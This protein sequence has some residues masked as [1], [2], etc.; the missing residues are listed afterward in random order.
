[1]ITREDQEMKKVSILLSI[2]RPDRE[3]L[4]EQLDSLNNQTYPNLELLVWNDCPDE[5]IDRELFAE[6]I[7]RFPVFYYG[8]KKNLGYI[9]AF[10]KLT[11]LAKGDLVSFCDQDDIW[12]TEKIEKCVSAMRESGAIAAVCDKSL[13]TANGEVYVKSYRATSTMHCDRWNTGDD[14]TPRAAFFC[15]GT[16]MTIVADRETVQG[17]LPFVPTVTHDMQLMLFLSAKGKIA[18]VDEPL[19]RYRR[20]GK[21]ET[22]LLYGVEKK[23]D[24]YDTRCKPGLDLMDRFAE[25]FP[26]YPELPEMIQ[27][28]NARMNGNAI[29]IWKHRRFLPDLYPYEIGLALCPDFVFRG[30]K[31]LLLKALRKK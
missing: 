28:A 5:P 6:C 26:S 14:I 20:H 29:G 4:K 24:Y 12:E 9:K 1:M 22:G 21:N 30:I 10:E 18:Y 2:Y 13:M 11:E 19:V 25:L 3:K 7:T 27:C 31:S 17:F 8:G 15:Y 23:K 16:G